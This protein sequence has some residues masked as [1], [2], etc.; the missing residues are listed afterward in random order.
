[1]CLE[2]PGPSST[3][4]LAQDGTRTYSVFINANTRIFLDP[5]ARRTAVEFIDELG[6][7]RGATSIAIEGGGPS[8]RTF[9]NDNIVDNVLQ[10]TCTECHVAGGTAVSSGLVFVPDF[11]PGAGDTNFAALV[12]YLNATPGND[13]V[14]TSVVTGGQGHPAVLDPNGILFTNVV[15]FLDLLATE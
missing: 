5:T 9:F 4:L 8:A 10:N 3:G 12:G 7:V 1:M 13:A 2:D 14:L 6:N 11:T 15:S